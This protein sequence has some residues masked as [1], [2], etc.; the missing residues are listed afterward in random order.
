MA[1][2]PKIFFDLD[3]TLIFSSLNDP[4]QNNTLIKLTD[5]FYYVIFRSGAHDLIDF[6][7]DLVGED[8]VFILTLS[9]NQYAQKINRVLKLGILPENVL[10]HDIWWA[11]RRFDTDNYLIDNEGVM[12]NETKL[13]YLNINKSWDNYYIQVPA[14]YGVHR[15]EPLFKDRVENILLDRIKNPAKVRV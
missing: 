9:A 12:S 15:A 5:T 3:E 7:K 10:S 8:N 2:H 11:E 1:G 13:L 14:F 6:A 4:G